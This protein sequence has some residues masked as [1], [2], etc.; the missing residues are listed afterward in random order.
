[1]PAA[2]R[3][4]AARRTDR[5]PAPTQSACAIVAAIMSGNNILRI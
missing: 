1:L 2:V 3:P 4:A 5:R